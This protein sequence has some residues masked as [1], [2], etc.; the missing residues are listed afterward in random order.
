MKKK[1]FFILAVIIISLIFIIFIKRSSHSFAQEK[2]S[3]IS[4]STE[5]QEKQIV[6][7]KEKIASK[8][9]Q[10][11]KENTQGISG[12]ITK[13]KDDSF[14][15]Q[16]QKDDIYQINTDHIVTKY[17]QI[18]DN[19]RK[20][21]NKEDLSKDQYVI[22]DGIINGNQIEANAIYIDENFL[23]NAGQVVEINK[24]EYWIKV[25]TL[26]KE[27]LILDIETY[28]KKSLLNIKNLELE[29]IG[30][31][32]IKEGDN[33]H[34]VIKKKGLKPLERASAIRLVV[35]P[36]EFFHKE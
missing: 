25:L 30:F 9:A 14:F 13:I 22:I 10:L 1:L 7:L 36:Q 11:K 24:N 18:I 6:E 33:V 8:V 4:G 34:F 15:I 17:Y 20:E 27:S 31:S 21:I 32:K 26:E 19:Q 2:I 12:Y 35:I 5:K 23:I 29:N 16:N 28:T 3:S